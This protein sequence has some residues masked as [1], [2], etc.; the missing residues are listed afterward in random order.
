[1]CWLK[2]KNQSV[3]FRMLSRTNYVR[4]VSESGERC[5]PRPCVGNISNG[6]QLVLFGVQN[7]TL[8]AYLALGRVLATLALMDAQHH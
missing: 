7:R 5:K 1:M 8:H 2:S 4:L 3:L 6:I